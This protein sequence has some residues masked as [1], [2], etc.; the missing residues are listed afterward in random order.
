MFVGHVDLSSAW[1]E[2]LER[3]AN[4]RKIL[5]VGILE[6]R[7]YP[8]EGEE[9]PEFIELN[10]EKIPNPFRNAKRQTNLPVAQVAYWQAYGTPTIPARPFFRNTLEDKQE[11]WIRTVRVAMENNGLDWESALTVLGERATKDIQQTIENHVPPPNSEL[12]KAIKAA[13]GRA[14]PD[15]TLIDSGYMQDSIDYEVVDS[16]DDRD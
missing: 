3:I 10:G 16:N 11:T 9:A 4:S 12:T 13:K 6:G 2:P 1:R 7:V 14:K 15:A 8:D 5:N